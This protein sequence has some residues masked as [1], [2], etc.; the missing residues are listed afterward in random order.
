MLFE[1]G[2]DPIGESIQVQGVYFTVIGVVK[3]RS[4]GENGD[5]ENQAIF[6]PLSTFQK[7]FNMGDRIGWVALLVKPEVK[8][9]LG[10]EKVKALLRKRHKVHPDD[11]RAIGSWNMEE[12][13]GQVR[14]LFTGIRW[15]SFTVGFFTLLAGAI[16]VSNIMLIIVKERTR[17]IGVRRAMGA[18]PMDVFSQI[19]TE[20]AVLTLLAGI[21]GVIF[22]VWLLEGLSTILEAQGGGGSFT[23]PGVNIAL[24]TGALIALVAIGLFAGMI[25]ARKAVAVKPITA[26]RDE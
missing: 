23:N 11:I 9:S 26:L 12:D 18:T 8:A 3:S 25:P 1:P 22:G 21:L 20:S 24:V 10:E 2:E 4:E 7:A 17:E 19:L 16:G 15:L 13:F 14:G 6:I 5:E